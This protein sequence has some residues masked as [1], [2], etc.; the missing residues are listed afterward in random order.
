MGNPA[1]A[2]GADHAIKVPTTATEWITL[3]GDIQVAF[4]PGTSGTYRTG[5]YWL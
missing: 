5:D 1:T 2:D 4:E 3:E